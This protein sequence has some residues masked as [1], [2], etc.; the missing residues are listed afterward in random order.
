MMYNGQ[1]TS[2]I[3]HSVS[4]GAVTTTWGEGGG[5]YGKECGIQC[6]ESAKTT[7][8]LENTGLEDKHML[9]DSVGCCIIHAVTHST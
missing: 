2:P 8:A 1:S 6:V 7:Q 3:S 9:H 5:K 4:P